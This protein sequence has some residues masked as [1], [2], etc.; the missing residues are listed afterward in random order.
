TGVIFVE[1]E[2]DVV[3][4]GPGQDAVAEFRDLLAF[5]ED[6]GVLADEIDTADMAVEVDAHAGPVEA[7]CDLLDM[8]RLAGAVI[9]A[10]EDAAI[11][12]EA[13]KDGE[14]GLAVEEIVGV[15]IGNMLIRLGIGGNLEIGID[16]KDLAH[17]YFHV[18]Q[19]RPLWTCFS[20]N[21]SVAAS[22]RRLRVLVS[23]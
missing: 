20:H 14:R 3:L 21:T 12:R 17:R 9:A 13:G 5:L 10:D 16:A 6:D 2:G 23:A 11:A 4:I 7:R 19:G 1:A 22:S 18:G 8:R 15:E